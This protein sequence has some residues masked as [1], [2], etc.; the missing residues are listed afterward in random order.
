MNKIDKALNIIYNN[1][2]YKYHIPVKIYK[3]PRGLLQAE[4]IDCGGSY[5]KLYKFYTQYLNEP[6][7]SGYIKTKYYY[8]SKINNQT[9]KE[10]NFTA[11]DIS[12]V[13]SLPIKLVGTH[14]LELKNI[15][16]VIF[17]LLHE[18]GHQVL[19]S[20]YNYDERACD[21]FAIRWIRKFWKKGIIKK[22]WE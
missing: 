9:Q 12:G 17:I 5:K 11:L 15:G 18:I 20:G 19:W 16:N 10:K 21:L 8:P 22:Y 6:P 3:T 1:S 2:P 14:L 4:A 13:G 7:V